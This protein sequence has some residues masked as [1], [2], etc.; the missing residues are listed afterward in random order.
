MF[1]FLMENFRSSL[2]EKPM[3]RKSSSRNP[4]MLTWRAPWMTTSSATSDISRAPSTG[5]GPWQ[6]WGSSR[7]PG[8][9]LRAPHLVTI[10]LIVLKIKLYVMNLRYA[11]NLLWFPRIYIYFIYTIF[12]P[13]LNQD[14]IKIDE[15]VQGKESS[16]AYKVGSKCHSLF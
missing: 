10:N 8:L 7:Q 15:I 3:L 12:R 11:E 9:S 4:R 14:W 5:W 16:D 6:P 2:M 1:A 13:Y